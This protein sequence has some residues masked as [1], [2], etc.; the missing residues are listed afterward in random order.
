MTSL[1][2]LHINVSGEPSSIQ[3]F[4][5]FYRT[6]RPLKWETLNDLA[7]KTIGVT[8]GYVYENV[9]KDLKRK[10]TVTFLES[11]SDEANFKM[12]LARRIDAF[13]MVRR[14]GYSIVKSILPA[15]QQSQIT[16]SPRS[17]A[18]FR[19]HLL[20]SKAVPQNEQRMILFDH[21]LARL[22]VSITIILIPIN[23]YFAVEMDNMFVGFSKNEAPYV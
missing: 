16:D 15:E 11:S 12:L 5:F 10:G 4:A 23:V 9:F 13:P 20:L 14:V 3:E 21:A 6:D 2:V 18:R 7:G 19:S 1:F 22:K 8:T 17:F